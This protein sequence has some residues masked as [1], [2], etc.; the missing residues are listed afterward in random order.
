MTLLDI[1][2]IVFLAVVVVLSAWGV[3]KAITE[4]EE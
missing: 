2:F 4:E 3:Y 1:S